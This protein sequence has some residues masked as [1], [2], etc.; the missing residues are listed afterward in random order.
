[1]VNMPIVLLNSLIICSFDIFE[2][3]PFT[4]PMFSVL[5]IKST[6]GGGG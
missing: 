1:L 4:P 2:L 3:S 6:E 5:I